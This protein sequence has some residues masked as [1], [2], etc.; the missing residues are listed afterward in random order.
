LST[1]VR[2]TPS[3]TENA[4]ENKRNGRF[5]FFAAKDAQ[6]EHQKGI[7]DDNDL[8]KMRNGETHNGANTS[9][10][11]SSMLLKQLHVKLLEMLVAIIGYAVSSSSSSTCCCCL[12]WL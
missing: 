9:N 10:L 4:E 2:E 11:H 3:E 6:G 12:C 5:D 1:S 8:K 7:N